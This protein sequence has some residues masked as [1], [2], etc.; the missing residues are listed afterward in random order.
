MD[1]T[2]I[3]YRATKVVERFLMDGFTS[4]R[5]MGGPTFGLQ[6]N[7]DSGI[8]IGPRIYPSGSFISQTSGHGDFR[9]RAEPGIVVRPHELRFSTSASL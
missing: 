2:D 8:I 5:D 1:I 9:E 6:R 7:I 3:S 4:V